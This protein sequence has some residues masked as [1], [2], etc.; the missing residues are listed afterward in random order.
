M[1]KLILVGLGLLLAINVAHAEEKTFTLPVEI[2]TPEKINAMDIENRRAAGRKKLASNL[3]QIDSRPDTVTY[4]I[5]KETGQVFGDKSIVQAQQTQQATRRSQRKP[6]TFVEKIKKT[7]KPNQNFNLKP[8]GNVVLPVAAGL[9]N[10]VSTNFK[11]LSVKTHN[12]SAIIE[13]EDGI[14]YIT[15][16]T[17]E[18]VGIMLFE[19]GVPESMIN[20]TLFPFD[21]MLPTMIDVAIK[22]TNAMM[23]KSEA[24]RM[25]L[26]KEV[27]LA[28]AI[29]TSTQEKYIDKYTKRIEVLLSEVA[30]GEI[31]AGFSLS[32]KIPKE[33]RNYPCSMP[34]SNYTAQRIVGSRE[35]ID[36]ILVTNDTDYV[37]SVREQH[38]YQNDALAAAVSQRA[39]L[40][41][42]EST[43]MYILRDKLHFSRASSNKRRPALI[44]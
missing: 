14:M 31:P 18:P 44:H 26:E 13:L 28:K 23:Q 6:I 34:I 43:E 1:K 42:G 11:R 10:R 3:N 20:L 27:A 30:M 24:F 40:Q 37:Y 33:V 36:V 38:C 39:T 41:P 25:N 16:K 2:I 29:E 12:E 15:I 9:T 7:W 32:T 19:E 5:P 8:A 4:E 22:M 35:V 17:L 21:Q